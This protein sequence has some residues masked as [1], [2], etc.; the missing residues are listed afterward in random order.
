LDA[1]EA[2]EAAATLSARA[3]HVDADM[4]V[5]IDAI[6]ELKRVSTRCVATAC[7]SKAICLQHVLA[8]S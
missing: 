4:R 3:R 1:A 6:L 2:A 5:C 8:H 7:S